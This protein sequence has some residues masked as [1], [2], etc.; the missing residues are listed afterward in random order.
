MSTLGV[1]FALSWGALGFL[2]FSWRRLKDDYASLEIFSLTILSLLFVLI[3][4]LL[5]LFLGSR[6]KVSP[7]FDPR[8]L[9]FWF[10]VLFGLGGF[11]AG[12]RNSRFMFYEA[13]EAVIVG[14]LFWCFSSFI[15]F[16]VPISI[17][18]VVLMILFSVLGQ[19]YKNFTWYRSGKVGFSGLSV[20]GT[21]FL[22]RTVLALINPNMISFIGR[23]DAVVSA[24]ATFVCFVT[25]Y[26]LSEI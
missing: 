6:L 7:L 11:V 22:A 5:G 16:S 17:F 23:I 25:L 18:I 19:R 9:W 26:N 15:L 1:I 20:M 14:F 13:L 10:S 24:I 3:G 12:Y 21:F 2:F 4:F 8:Q